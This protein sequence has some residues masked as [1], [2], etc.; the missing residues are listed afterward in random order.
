MTKL[1]EIEFLISINQKSM[2]V[3]EF[4]NLLA[5]YMHIQENRLKQTPI[6]KGF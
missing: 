5:L 1:G 4:E 2:I 3:W 6:D